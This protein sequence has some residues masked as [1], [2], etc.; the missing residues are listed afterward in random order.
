MAAVV[1]SSYDLAVTNAMIEGRKHILQSTAASIII[2]IIII[3]I[4]T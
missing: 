3:I 2:I 4:M 1:G